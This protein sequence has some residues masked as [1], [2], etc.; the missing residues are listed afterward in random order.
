MRVLV[1]Y[2]GSAAAEQ[3]IADLGRAGL[4]DR[5]EAVVLTV[6]DVLPPGEVSLASA[7]TPAIRSARTAAE[8]ALATSRELA[9]RG[10]DVVSGVLS[11]WSVEAEAIAD[12]P[13]WGVVKRAEGWPADLVIVGSHGRSMLDRVTLGSVSQTVARNAHCSVR[14]GRSPRRARGEPA[15]LLVGID[16]SESAAAA[17]EAVAHRSWP[18]GSTVHVL[19]CEDSSVVTALA[20]RDTAVLRW[21]SPD[22]ADAG[23]WIRRAVD[24][25]VQRVR[26]AGV[27]AQGDV[28]PGDPKRLLV[29]T[30][31]HLD[32]DCI[33]V[34]AKGLSRIERFLLGSVSA[35]VA[36]KARCSVEIVRRTSS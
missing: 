13:F 20:S 2:D 9:R 16:G 6:A 27:E 30:A 8:A 22:D 17:V 28:R 34:G 31:E 15:R 18:A 24:A 1:G 10:A 26:E 21:A 35:A 4:P 36:A 32:A 19:A 5:G 29:E 3:A 25:A 23:A 11:G 12:S 14:I 7:D 33:L